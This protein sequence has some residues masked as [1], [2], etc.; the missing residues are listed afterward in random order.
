MIGPRRLKAIYDLGT[1]VNI[2]HKLIYDIVLQFGSLLYT[3]MSVGL[4]D[5]ST[6]QVGLIDDIYL[7]VTDSYVAADF[8]VL[9]RGHNLEAPIILGR[10]FLSTTKATIYAD[11]SDI[12]FNI[13]GKEEGFSFKSHKP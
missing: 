5:Q 4:V 8:V 12:C 13:I 1:S 9:D 3:T 6:C 11:T 2:I 10:P 7:L